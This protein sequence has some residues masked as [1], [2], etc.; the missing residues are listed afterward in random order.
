VLRFSES[1]GNQEHK[2][3]PKPR[4]MMGLGAV[5][6]RY[7]QGKLRFVVSHPCDKNKNAPRMRLPIYL[8]CQAANL[9]NLS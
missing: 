7:K 6:G 1:C 5:A 3:R 8:P 9:F 4:Y 2:K